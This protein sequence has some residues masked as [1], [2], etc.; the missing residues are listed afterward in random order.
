PCAGG[1]V[2][3]RKIQGKELSFNNMLDLD[4]ALSMTLD[5]KQPACAIVKHTNPCGFAHGKDLLEAFKRAYASDPISAFGSVISFN[6]CVDKKTAET[7][8]KTLFVE[9]VIAKDFD[10]AAVEVFKQKKNCRLLAADFAKGGSKCDFKKI[11]GGLLV[12]D[13]D[14]KDPLESDLKVVTKLKP[15]KGQIADLLFAFRVCRYA[16]SNTIVIAK[17]LA[18]LGM[19]MGQP[20]RVDSCQ[21]ACVKAG[22]RARGAV[23]ASDGFF[24]KPDSIALAK[25][26]GISAIIQPGGSIL[27]QTIIDACDKARIAMVFTGIRHFTH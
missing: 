8:L 5:L 24:P 21:T 7:L 2:G 25:K 10:K 1:V 9:C 4:A 14:V 23:L 3:A 20:S 12:Q 15:R 22:K 13:R 18:T 26:A 27:D 19:G 16:K 17:N 6:G 11:S